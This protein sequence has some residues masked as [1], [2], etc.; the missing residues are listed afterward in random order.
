MVGRGGDLPYVS[1]DVFCFR[2]LA[3]FLVFGESEASA[4]SLRAGIVYTAE[5]DE[6]AAKL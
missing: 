4:P 1:G 2:L 3:H 6:P 5:T